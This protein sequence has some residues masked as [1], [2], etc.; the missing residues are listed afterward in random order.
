MKWPAAWKIMAAKELCWAFGRSISSTKV[1]CPTPRDRMR[2][3]PWS[4]WLS[5]WAR[6]RFCIRARELTRSPPACPP[7]IMLRRVNRL[8]L[9]STCAR[10]A[11]STRKP[12]RR[13]SERGWE[14]PPRRFATIPTGRNE[15]RM[16]HESRSRIDNALRKRLLRVGWHARPSPPSE[17]GQLALRGAPPASSGRNRLR[18]TREQSPVSA[19]FSQENSPKTF[20]LS[21]RRLVVKL[22]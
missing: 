15:L 20:P 17:V 1:A 10:P 11:F 22:H 16:A 9:S 13:L 6:K 5:Q 14:N 21:Q 12:R 3:K 18:E 8:L 19:C 2:S 4:N 7:V